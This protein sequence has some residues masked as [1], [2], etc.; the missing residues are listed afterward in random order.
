MIP[1][2]FSGCLGWLHPGTG[3]RGVVLCPPWG[4][5]A[6]CVHR[7]LLALAEALAAVGL[8][9]LRFELPG[10]GDSLDPTPEAPLPHH[11]IAALFAAVDLLR[12]RTG[13]QQVA[14]VGLRLGALLVAEAAL[15]LG[16]V[17][18]LVLLAPPATGRALLRELRAWARL[19][20][21]GST[22][23]GSTAANDGLVAGGFA[24]DGGALAALARL[25][26]FASPVPPASRLLILERPDAPTRAVP[27]R[28]WGPEAAVVE[29][30]PFEGFTELMR[31]PLL[32]EPPRRT[33]DRVVRF[34]AEDAPAGTPR[35]AAAVGRAREAVLEGPGFVE[36]TLR[37]GPDDRLV[38]TLCEPTP[39]PSVGDPP[40]LLILNTG[41]T[42][43]AGAGRSAVELARALALDGVGSLRLDL[44]GIGDSALPPGE[45]AGDIYRRGAILEVRAALDLLEARGARAVVGLGVCSGAFMAFHAALVDPR[46][47]GLV[48][49]NLPRFAW[50]PFHPLVFVR[51]RALLALLA[52]PATWWRALSRRGELVPAL[53]VLAE[54]LAARTAGCLPRP[55]RRLVVAASWPARALRTLVERG[56]RLLVLYAADDPGLPIF[57]RLVDG[58]R[59][60][61]TDGRFEVRVVEG[62]GHTFAEPAARRLLLGSVQEHLER[63]RQPRATALPAAARRPTRAAA[64]EAV[65]P[66]T[67]GPGPP[68]PAGAEVEAGPRVRRMCLRIGP[69]AREC[70]IFEDAGAAPPGGRR[71]DG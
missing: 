47:V 17:D 66:R 4:F 9:C 8:P 24:L 37:F 60:P 7:S 38:A 42:P 53:R 31:D 43:R 10:T 14:L 40:A 57:D 13:A 16:G 5:E 41:A 52:H 39:G 64:R 1:L 45:A 55:L 18:R 11:W 28:V 32:S 34:L 30:G 33:I 2:A 61:L 36:R 50:R 26:P 46:L 12:T 25:D 62:V 59:G 54:R 44:G 6:L 22:D 19:S 3:G 29:V 27:G 15:R 69:E 49:V 56:V 71:V 51:T 35:R 58:A 20:E 65:E 68:E 70:R 63:L 21:A 48:L 23:S 67:S